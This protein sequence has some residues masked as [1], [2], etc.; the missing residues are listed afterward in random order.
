MDSLTFFLESYGCSFNTADAETMR[1]VLRQTGWSEVAAP[2]AARLIVVNSCT[3]KDRTTLE[4]RKRLNALRALPQCPAVILAGCAP[5]VPSQ[6]KEFRDFTMLGP[7]TLEHLPRLAQDLLATGLPVSCVER[8]P[9]L[10]SRLLLPHER[11]NPAVEIIP[12]AQGCLGSCSYCQTVVARGRLHSARPSVI[13]RRMET[14]LEQGVRTFWLT[15]QDCGAYGLDIGTNLT[16]LMNAV[17]RTVGVLGAANVRVRVGMANPD[18]IGPQIQG[19]TEAL[20]HPC[21]FKFAHIPVQCGS[22]H[23]LKLMRRP[24]SVQAFCDQ[25][26]ALRAVMPEISIATDVIVGFP[27]ETD[28][29]FEETLQLM[30]LLVPSVINRSRFSARPHT[31]AARMPQVPTK[32]VSARSQ[33]LARL[34]EK[35]VAKD[36]GALLG[37]TVHAVIEQGT[38]ARTDSYKPVALRSAGGAPPPE[39]PPGTHVLVRLTAVS[40]FHLVGEILN[41]AQEFS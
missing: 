20:A 27:G 4:L 30:R 29:D 3:V 23:V 38:L 36:L 18:H 7:D 15:A 1:A 22:D 31:A 33:R 13:L 26:S 32:T 12:I 5:R 11:T 41:P 9:S 6:A 28:E 19:F 39:L 21:F 2:E 17:S 34:H 35:L 14:A 40:R 10:E 16:E 37:Q 8:A 25:V 24:Y